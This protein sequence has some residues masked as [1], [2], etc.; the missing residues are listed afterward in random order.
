MEQYTSRMVEC[1][2][3]RRKKL[4]IFA[5][6]IDSPVAAAYLIWPEQ[7]PN[8]PTGFISDG[9]VSVPHLCSTK[10]IFKFEK[11]SSPCSFHLNS[12]IRSDRPT[13]SFASKYHSLIL[14]CLVFI[15]SLLISIII[16]WIDLYAMKSNSKCSS[17]QR[18]SEMIVAP[19]SG[20]RARQSVGIDLG[21]RWSFQLIAWCEVCP[22]PGFMLMKS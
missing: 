10:S 6:S 13:A 22:G 19:Q 20:A 12:T 2:W 1:V 7:L 16:K 9:W 17:N 3:N 18:I 4:L 5:I 21:G 14:F 15:W 11:L 8:H